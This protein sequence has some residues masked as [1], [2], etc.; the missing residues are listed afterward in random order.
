MDD[1]EKSDYV[2][3]IGFAGSPAPDPDSGILG[4]SAWID[5]YSIAKRSGVDHDL[6]FRAI[7]ETFDYDGQVGGAAHGAV[8]RTSV[9]EAGHGGRNLP[10]MAVSLGQGVGG[11][12][13][14]PAAAL[15]STAL[16][17]WLPLVG[18]GELSAGRKPSTMRLKSTSLK[19]PRRATSTASRKRCATD[20]KICWGR[21]LSR[22]LKR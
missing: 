17:N 15:V 13:L 11:S 8:V 16:G 5:A 3:I 19:R 2:G 10:A 12:S 6:A 9:A 4:G 7:M 18:S 21:G 14:N 1:P 22:P 20:R